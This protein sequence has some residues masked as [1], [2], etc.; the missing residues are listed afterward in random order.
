MFQGFFY[1]RRE[2]ASRRTLLYSKGRCCTID[3]VNPAT[4][5]VSVITPNTLLI[6]GRGGANLP[7][8]MTTR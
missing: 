8:P 4:G 1:T 2:C 3:V 5:A 6:E 7:Y